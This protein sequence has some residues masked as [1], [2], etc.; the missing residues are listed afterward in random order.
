MLPLLARS[1]VV[2][3]AAAFR[4]DDNMKRSGSA[5]QVRLNVESFDTRFAF[6]EVQMVAAPHLLNGKCIPKIRKA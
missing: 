6:P 1:L 2:S 5:F 4:C 3:S